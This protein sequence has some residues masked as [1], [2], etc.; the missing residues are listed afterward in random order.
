M[1]LFPALRHYLTCQRGFLGLGG[2]KVTTTTSALGA[3]DAN[4]IRDQ[5][6]AAEQAAQAAMGVEVAGANPYTTGA[7]ENYAGMYG[8][9][10]G[11][12]AGYGGQAQ[13]AFDFANQTGMGGVGEYYQQPLLDQ[14]FANMNPQWA[15][16]M[17]MAGMGGQQGATSA[18]A[19]GG[20]RA[21]IASEYG[22]R[23]VGNAQMADYGAR[24]YDIGRDA[25][26]Y[27]MGER[28][29]M[30]RMGM[31]FAGLQGQYD[32]RRYG[33]NRDLML[34]GDYMRNIETE[35]NRSGFVNAAN[36]AEQTRL[37]Y[38]KDISSTVER[39]E[40]GSILGDLAGLATTAAGIA[41]PGAGSMLGQLGGGGGPQITPE[42]AAATQ[43]QGIMPPSVQPV[44]RW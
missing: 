16:Q 17:N 34:G 36:A 13:G 27:M 21:A 4:Q 39:R 7:M 35:Q 3:E 20:S 14:Y 31:G 22:R 32:D 28:E 29:R 42:M 5:R 10:G 37:G 25:A 44:G 1:Q 43:P 33:V 2:D 26:G 15:E 11:Q 18:G 30:Q 23:Q 41:M 6:A 19:Y 38:G 12:A 9:F 40:E 8:E 24:T